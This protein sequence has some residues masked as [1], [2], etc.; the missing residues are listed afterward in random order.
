[1]SVK[2]KVFTITG[3]ASGMGLETAKLFASKGAKLSLADI[4]EKPLK[5]LEA[6]LLKSGAEVMSRIVNVSKR[7]DV[8]SWIADTVEKFGKIDGA[9][10]LAGVIGKQSSVATIEE[11][12]DD[13]WDFIMGVNVVGLRNCL[14]AEVPHMNKGSAILNAASILGL[15]GA[16]KQLAY[17]ASKHAVVGMTRCAA[18]ELGPKNIRVNCICPGPVDTAML[19]NSYELQGTVVDYSWLPLGRAAHQ[20]EVPP[21]IEFLL[22][23]ASS[24]ITGNAMPI[25]GGWYC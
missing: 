14:R 23:D 22:T 12:E 11:V 5:E 10:N 15:V 1:M 19:R 21:L 18:K 20:K 24:F 17:C 25:D 8:D 2:G 16:P 6:E 7:A 4:Q 9:A 13:D 3:A